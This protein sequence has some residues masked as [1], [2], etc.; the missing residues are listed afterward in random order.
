MPVAL[1]FSLFFLPHFCDKLGLSELGWK[2][3]TSFTT[4]TT[5]EF[6]K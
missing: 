1:S 3:E 4:E 6:D 5:Q 2:F